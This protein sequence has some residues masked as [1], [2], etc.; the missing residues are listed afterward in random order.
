MHDQGSPKVAGWLAILAGVWIAAYWLT[1]GPED[2]RRPAVSMDRTP[3]VEPARQA[4]ELTGRRDSSPRNDLGKS[5]PDPDP[6]E[7]VDIEA[8]PDVVPPT[9]YEYTVQRGDTYER[10]ARR[11][12]GDAGW[13]RAIAN[14]ND[15]EPRRLREGMVILIPVDP[16]NVQGVPAEEPEPEPVEADPVFTEY[17]VERGDTL[18]G[19]ARALYGRSSLWTLIRDANRD[20]VNRDGTNIRPGM[21]LRIPP[22]PLED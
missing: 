12:L 21:T 7:A 19:I 14:S 8:T 9:F 1:P 20:Q 11:E 5:E 18:G 16:R 2:E 13:W 10:I 17:V 6:R 3:T 15:V 22:P 4:P